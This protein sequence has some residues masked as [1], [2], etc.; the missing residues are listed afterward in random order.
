M[1]NVRHTRC[2]WLL[3]ALAIVAA[4]IAC[5]VLGSTGST[6]EPVESPTTLPTQ[7][8]PP[9]VEDVGDEVIEDAEVDAS[10]P[11]PAFGF[12]QALLLAL[13]PP[14]NY[15][16]LTDYMGDSFEI[17][18]WYGNGEQMA[19]AEAA[20]ALQNAFL[21]P[22]NT[23]TFEEADAATPLLGGNPY[24]LYPFAADFFFTRGWGAAGEDEAL[25]YIAQNPDGSFY[26]SGML[27][28][29]GGFAANP[30][31]AESSGWQPLPA[32][33]CQDLLESTAT[34]L[35]VA[36]ATLNEGAP[37]EDYL[38]GTA[39]TGCLI[40]ANGTGADFT[41]YM[42]VYAQLEEMLTTQGWT[43]DMQYDGGGPTGQIG[44]FRRDSA[45]L[46]LTVG[47]EPSEDADCP[48]DQ[49]ISACS[50]TP[51]QQIYTITLTAAMQ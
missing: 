39:G 49:P 11:D 27:Y 13:T 24:Q 22:G 25:L 16:A 47:W 23:L 41:S 19:P 7:T 2:A 8:P 9:P 29:N 4:Q 37:F 18:I 1:K 5:G 6:T 42:D 14:R 28:A 31:P 36:T 10:A 51:E 12:K 17:M 50:L 48:E 20:D 33:I 34:T 44:G 38:G 45:L 32:G 15:D 46:L 26:W 40:T 21:P 43:S 30:P 3:P 35:D